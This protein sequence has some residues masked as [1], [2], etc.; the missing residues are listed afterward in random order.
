MKTI[1]VLADHDNKERKKLYVDHSNKLAESFKC[2]SNDNSDI[3]EVQKLI[4]KE[5]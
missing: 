1:S 5:N 2:N 4:I 3:D